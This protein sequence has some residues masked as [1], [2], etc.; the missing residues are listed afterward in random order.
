M[1]IKEFAD[2]FPG[3]LT[4]LPPYRRQDHRIETGNEPRIALLPYRLSQI[5]LGELK[6]QHNEL[7]ATGYIRP[8][9]SPWSAPVLFVK[10]RMEHF[11]CV[12]TIVN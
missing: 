2:I 5:E 3:N 8:S 9:C 7:E 11:A 1:L 4:N 10:K 6:K 12:L